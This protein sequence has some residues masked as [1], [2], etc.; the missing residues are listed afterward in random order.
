M[1]MYTPNEKFLKKEIK[2]ARAQVRV[3]II[4]YVCVFLSLSH[5]YT[6]AM[7]YFIEL[8]RRDGLKALL[9]FHSKVFFF[10][11][12]GI[13]FAP[14]I[15]LTCSVFFLIRYINYGNDSVL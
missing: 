5:T 9:L 15:T 4:I 11:L 8:E 14:C 6:Q 1:C 2:R 12:Q 10:Y 7:C 3:Y 13:W